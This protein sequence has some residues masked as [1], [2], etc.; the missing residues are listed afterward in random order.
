MRTS[1]SAVAGGC[2]LLA[3][4]PALAAASP[5]ASCSPAAPAT[6]EWSARAP[7]ASG[8]LVRR[9]ERGQARALKASELCGAARAGCRQAGP[10]HALARA[11][12]LS[13]SC[14]A[15]PDCRERL[16]VSQAKPVA[17]VWL[18]QVRRRASKRIA[19][20][21]YFERAL[22][23]QARGHARVCREATRAD[24]PAAPGASPSQCSPWGWLQG[25]ARSARWL[26]EALC[27]QA[28]RS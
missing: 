9:G 4:Q 27:S 10:G 23:V 22:A 6:H 19:G 24:A 26:D 8:A 14:A 5:A 25:R 15:D 11:A 21:Q 20:A 17:Q 16:V 3:K 13:T 12:K 18:T 7:R 1:L 2:P 28:C